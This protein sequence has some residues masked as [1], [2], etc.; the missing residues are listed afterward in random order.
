MGTMGQMF[1][2]IDQL[3][4]DYHDEIMVETPIGQVTA[5]FEAG[6]NLDWQESP[7]NAWS[8]S[9][10]YS[11]SGFNSYKSGLTLDNQV[12]STG[13]TLDVTQA[14]NIEFWYRVSAEYSV[15]GNFFYDG[16]EFY[17]NGQ[18]QAQFQTE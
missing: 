8:I 2:M 17:I 13:V 6:L 4:T 9:S 18:L 5:D 3:N 15:S 10:D 16:L 14:G 12:S 11:H 1:V 7:F